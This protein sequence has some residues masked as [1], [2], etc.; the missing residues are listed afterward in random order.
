M[1]YLS[2]MRKGNISAVPL[3]RVEVLAACFQVPL[4]SFRQPGSPGATRDAAVR[5]ALAQPLV[6]RRRGGWSV[7]G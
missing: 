4:D 6:W 2:H 5:E 1:P 7:S 3:Q